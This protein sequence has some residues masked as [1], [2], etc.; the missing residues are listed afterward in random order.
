[1]YFGDRSR[2][3]ILI[4]CVIRL[5]AAI[6]NQLLT[7]EEFYFRVPTRVYVSATPNPW[8]IEQSNHH[9][10]EQLIRPTGITDPEIEIRPV[11][12]Q[13]PDLVVEIVKRLKIGQRTLVTTLTKR[14]AED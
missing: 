14:M 2:K 13:I 11:S 12:N 7:F 1:M 8:E 10:V 9:V 6:Y 5:A 3:Q 4:D